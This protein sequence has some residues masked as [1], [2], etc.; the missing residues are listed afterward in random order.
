[1]TIEVPNDAEV[2]FDAVA[3]VAATIEGV[4]AVFA[5]GRGDLTTPDD[6]P[7]IQPMIDETL[8]VSPAA[9]LY[10]GEWE[11]IPGSWEQQKHQ[12]ELTIWLEQHPIGS[13]YAE[14]IAFRQR[15]LDAFPPHAKA[16][17]HLAELSSVLIT[18]G[19][20]IEPRVWPEGSDRNYLTVPVALEVEL[21]RAA[22]YQPR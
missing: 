17:E 3:K 21:R 11:V 19:R 2:W 13:A 15:V 12:V 7:R 8:M 5:G 18:G 14:A 20:G 10:A 9:V 4:R 1:M 22:Q 6:T 16:Y